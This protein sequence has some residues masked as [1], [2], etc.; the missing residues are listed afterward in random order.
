MLQVG[1]VSREKK[2]KKVEVGALTAYADE[3][4]APGGKPKRGDQFPGRHFG[5]VATAHNV[6][7]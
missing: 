1:S 6:G 4:G 2:K 7:L 5:F 3:L